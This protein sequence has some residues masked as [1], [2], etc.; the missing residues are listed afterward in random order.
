MRVMLMNYK[1]MKKFVTLIVNFLG[2]SG[3]MILNLN[4][5][6]MKINQILK[7]LN[8]M[9]SQNVVRMNQKNR[10]LYNN[11]NKMFDLLVA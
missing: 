9:Y 4:Y 3:C 11:T 10:H 2:K 1:K 5:G 6:L 8:V 7:N